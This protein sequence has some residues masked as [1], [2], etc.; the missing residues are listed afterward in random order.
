MI[1][2]KC[3]YEGCGWKFEFPE[4]V[5]VG[6]YVLKNSHYPFIY[7]EHVIKAHEKIPPAIW[8]R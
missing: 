1:T 8:E 3:G 5:V 7:I 2:I 6:E 4:N